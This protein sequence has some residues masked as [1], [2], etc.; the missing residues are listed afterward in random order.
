[1]HLL[2]I[3]Q[4]ELEIRWPILGRK[5]VRWNKMCKSPT[6]SFSRSSQDIQGIETSLGQRNMGEAKGAFIMG[7]WKWFMVRFVTDWHDWDSRSL[8]RILQ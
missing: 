1:M 6:E 5:K 3:I 2:M 8:K 7:G 4:K